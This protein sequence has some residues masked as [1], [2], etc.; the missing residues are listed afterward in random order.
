MVAGAA[1]YAR[2]SA[3]RSSAIRITACAALRPW[4]R[5]SPAGAGH[6]LLHRLAGDDAER[7]RDA[8]VELDVLDPA[9]ASA[10]T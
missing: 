7:A 9:A 10:Q 6:R 3:S 8:G 4:S 2:T 5:L 1:S